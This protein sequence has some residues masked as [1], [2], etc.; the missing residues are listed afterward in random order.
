MVMS[1]SMLMMVMGTS[2]IYLSTNFMKKFKIKLGLSLFTIIFLSACQ[3]VSLEEAEEDTAPIESQ[4]PFQFEETEFDFGV[5]KQSGGIVTHDF[6]F[7]YQGEEPIEITGV[8]GSCLCTE[9]EISQ[10]IFN[11]GDEGFLTVKFNPNLHAEPEG[12]FYKTVSILTE[13]KLEEMP[14]VKVWTEIDLDLGEEFFE[15]N[16]P[17]DD[18]D[19]QSTTEISHNAKVAELPEGDTHDFYLEAKEVIAELD[20]ELDYAYWTFDST[21]PGPM[22]R[23]KEGDTV[24][25]HLKNAPDSQNPHSIDLHAVNG[26]GGGAVATQVHPG[27]EASY[28]FTASHPGLYVYHCATPDVAQHMANGMYGMILV[29]PKEG[30]PEVDQEFYVMQG[31]VYSILDHGDTGVTQLSG[32]DL[33]KEQPNYIV[34]N[35]RDG[36]LTEEEALKVNVGDTVRLYV[37]NGGVAKV[38]NFHVIGEI[39]DKVY[40]E[41]GSLINENVQTTLIPAGGS[42]IV[43]FTVDEPGKYLLVDHALSRLNKGAVAE[44]I[45]N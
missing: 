32:E 11:P 20:E 23:V 31:E 40:V 36:A 9:G 6:K 15:L 3:Q 22:M 8:P 5:I 19:S 16:L 21:V 7:T 42:T 1:Q 44:L 25:I 43:E 45:A 10:E 28:T 41:G 35:G 17:H 27:E 37:G 29:E 30:L 14:E 34:F 33:N 13:P 39:F 18:E 2:F 38:S 4:G 24:N 12:R 26:P